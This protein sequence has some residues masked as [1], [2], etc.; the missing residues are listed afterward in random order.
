M[1]GVE[2]GQRRIFGHGHGTSCEYDL[3][4]VSVPITESGQCGLS[5]ASSMH[6]CKLAGCQRNPF[7]VLCL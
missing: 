6:Q 7:P 1:S 5:E 4:A 3:C 2:T